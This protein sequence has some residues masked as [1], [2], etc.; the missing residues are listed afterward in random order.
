MPKKSHIITIKF[1]PGSNFQKRSGL[2]SLKIFLTSWEIY[3]KNAH[4]YNEIEIEGLEKVVIKESDQ[5][6]PKV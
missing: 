4:K 3:Y 1:T 6:A 5:A 2:N